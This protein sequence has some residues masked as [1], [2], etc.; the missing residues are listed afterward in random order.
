MDEKY[1][2][3]FKSF[4]ELADDRSFSKRNVVINNVTFLCGLN[5][6]YVIRPSLNKYLLNHFVL[7]W[8]LLIANN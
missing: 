2:T 6:I 4:L 1:F 8:W 3:I 5:Y 7:T